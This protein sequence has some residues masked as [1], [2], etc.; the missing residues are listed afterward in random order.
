MDRAKGV[1]LENQSSVSLSL[2]HTHTQLPF[3]LE[4]KCFLYVQNVNDIFLFTLYLM[5]FLG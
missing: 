5:L 3:A 2:S 1:Y 4:T